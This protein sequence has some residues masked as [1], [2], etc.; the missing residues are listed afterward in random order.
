LHHFALLAQIRENSLRYRELPAE[1]V[2]A[3]GFTALPLLVER[4]ARFLSAFAG[5]APAA[6]FVRALPRAL[7]L[8]FA[9]AADCAS[10][11]CARP[12][13]CPAPV[14]A[15]VGVVVCAPDSLGRFAAES[16][17]RALSPVC[18]GGRFDC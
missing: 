6:V 16:P 10:A 1:L 18:T 13:G 3:S 2:D 14:A 11:G 15:P 12:W 9:L 17:G 8:V 5:F 7:L 4:C